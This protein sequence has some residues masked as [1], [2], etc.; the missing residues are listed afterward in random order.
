MGKA[1]MLAH[2]EYFNEIKDE[3]VHL[4]RNIDEMTVARAYGGGKT[5][6]DL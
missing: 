2:S 6:Y 4:L 5:L 3:A 1:I